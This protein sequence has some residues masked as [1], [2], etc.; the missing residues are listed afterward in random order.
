M[1]V[2]RGKVR[3]TLQTRKI[4]KEMKLHYMHLVANKNF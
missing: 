3:S 4:K 1:K 2:I